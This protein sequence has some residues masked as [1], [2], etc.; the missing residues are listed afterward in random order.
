MPDHDLRGDLKERID[1]GFEGWCWAPGRP[2]E[3][4]LID[5]LVN[6][7]VAASIVAAAFRRDLLTRGIGDGRSRQRQI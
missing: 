4:L 6:D 1:G 3:R 7:T 5:L 2:D